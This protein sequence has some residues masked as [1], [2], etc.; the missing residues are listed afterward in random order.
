MAQGLPSI[1]REQ[2]V[3]L[4]PHAPNERGDYL[5]YLRGHP[6]GVVTRLNKCI[7]PGA[8]EN[9]KKVGNYVKIF[10]C[11]DII[12]VLYYSLGTE[13]AWTRALSPEAG[14]RACLAI[15]IAGELFRKLEWE[16]QPC[17]ERVVLRDH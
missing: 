8:Q 7:L 13:S 3:P 10:F 5:G 1:E 12:F 17:L 4:R 16:G 15:V 2:Q 9:K 6:A 14:A 11:R